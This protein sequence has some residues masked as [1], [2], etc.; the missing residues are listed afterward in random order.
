MAHSSKLTVLSPLTS[1][2][3]PRILRIL[4]GNTSGMVT[5]LAQVAVSSR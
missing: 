5:L 1:C 4:T 3:F 2:A